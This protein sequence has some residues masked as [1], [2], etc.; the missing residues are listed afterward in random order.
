VWT[1]LNQVRLLCVST[2]CYGMSMVW[3]RFLFVGLLVVVGFLD[4]IVDMYNHYRSFHYVF[5]YGEP[6]RS[7]LECH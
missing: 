2:N 3:C 5:H 7:S 6:F 4:S 1:G